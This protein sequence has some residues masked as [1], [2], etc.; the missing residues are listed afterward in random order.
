[1]WIAYS[2]NIESIMT[3]VMRFKWRRN[4]R[5]ESSAAKRLRRNVPSPSHYP[6]FKLFLGA[7]WGQINIVSRVSNEY[8]EIQWIQI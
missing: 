1:M 3:A 8:K 5:G 4:G 2:V 7:W 6:F